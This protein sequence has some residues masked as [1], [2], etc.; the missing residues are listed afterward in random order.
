MFVF[1]RRIRG[2][3][4]IELL[5]VIAIIA[6]LIGLLLPAV[7]KV[8]EAANRMSCSN[9]LKQMGLALHNYDQT[10]GR[11]MAAL[12]HSGRYNNPNNRPYEGPEVSYKGQPY[13]IYNHTGFIAMLPYI[14]QENLFKQYRYD[15]VG[16]SSSPYGL[17]IGPNPIDNPNR[18]IAQTYIKIFTC[19]ADEN[20]PPQVDYQPYTTYWYERVGTRRS[21]YLFSAGHGTDYSGNY[22]GNLYYSGAFGNNGAAALSRIKDGNSNTIAIGEAKQILTSTHFG[23]YWGSGTH[24]AVHGYTP[25]GRPDFNVNYPFG[26]APGSTG[27]YRKTQYAW[28]FGS[29][30]SNGAN[31]VFC[32]GS[33]K[34]ISNGI[35]YPVFFALN[36]VNGGEV[37]DNSSY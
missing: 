23:P 12:I 30:H 34:F 32:D 1:S 20:P 11:L 14:E 7:Q 36:T 9:N 27:G 26:N 24:T 22:D 6:V 5:V 2:F 3:T 18:I 16:S 33:V 25:V 35:L 17:P 19:P 15:L 4:L 29:Y 8:R 37:F 28:G 21:N 10:N 31:F 13:V